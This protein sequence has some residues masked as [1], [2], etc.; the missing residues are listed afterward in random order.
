MVLCSICFIKYCSKLHSRILAR[1]RHIQKAV[2]LCSICLSLPFIHI[3]Y[4]KW[5]YITINSEI[6]CTHHQQKIKIH[7]KTLYRIKIHRDNLQYN[8]HHNVYLWIDSMDPRFVCHSVM[9]LPS[10]HSGILA[11]LWIKSKSFSSIF[12]SFIVK[13]PAWALWKNSWI[14]VA[15]CSHTVKVAFG[16]SLQ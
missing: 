11:N 1:E 13:I 5:Q 3:V 2:V 12:M 15:G 10:H 16:S 9:P 7:L 8:N 14:L 6:L 4:L